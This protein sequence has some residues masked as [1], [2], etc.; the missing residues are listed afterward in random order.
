MK[1]KIILLSVGLAFVA[2]FLFVG[3]SVAPAEEVKVTICHFPSGNPGNFHTIHVGSQKAADKHLANHTGDF[4]G[5]C[6]SMIDQVCGPPEND[7]KAWDCAADT[8][9][10]VDVQCDSVPCMDLTGCLPDGG[11]DYADRD[12]PAGTECNS[13]TDECEP[14]IT[15]ACPCWDRSEG[16]AGTSLTNVWSVHRPDNCEILDQC[17]DDSSYREWSIAQC[18]DS[19]FTKFF[20]SAMEDP[21]HLVGQCVVYKASEAGNVL[22]HVDV[23]FDLTDPTQAAQSADCLAEHRE[24]TGGVFAEP[25]GL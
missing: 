23:I 12:C 25:C 6:C 19:E 16:S 18:W 9:V 17:Q 24:F 10:S 1:R 5:E 11:C 2:S 7:C 21:S 14:T 8:C 22:F 3:P 15:G 20:T 4:M 13:A